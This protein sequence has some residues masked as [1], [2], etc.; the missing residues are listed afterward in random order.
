MQVNFLNIVLDACRN[1]L[2]AMTE[3]HITTGKPEIK[4][5]LQPETGGTVTG[6]ICMRGKFHSAS[7]A[8]IFSEESA[9]K[10]ALRVLPECQ[11][12]NQFLAFDLV[13]EI[14]NQIIGGAK[15]TLIKEGY[16]FQITL[17]TVISGYD[18][19]IAHQTKAP[20]LRIPLKSDFGTFFVEASFDG[21]PLTE[22]EKL[23][24][25][26]PEKFSDQSN[27]EFF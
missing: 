17:P 18:Y 1:V 13:G 27:V 4:K 25:P 24:K 20:V 12:Q 26:S 3:V 7:L 2:F 8:I 11:S 9:Q 23:N 6:I 19:L 15:A 22:K 5:K 16:S 10:I 21:P 14:S